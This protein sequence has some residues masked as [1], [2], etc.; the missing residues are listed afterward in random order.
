[1]HYFFRKKRLF[2]SWK[3]LAEFLNHHQTE[4]RFHHFVFNKNHPARIVVCVKDHSILTILGKLD[5]SQHVIEDMLLISKYILVKLQ[6][7]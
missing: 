4:I 5:H 6:P 1:M 3:L 7:V 2:N